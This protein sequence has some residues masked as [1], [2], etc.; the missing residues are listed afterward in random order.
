[1]RDTHQTAATKISLG[2]A[3][4]Y[5]R[6]QLRLVNTD[7]MAAA[8]AA[9]GEHDVLQL[10][11]EN[12]LIDE[13]TTRTGGRYSPDGADDLSE[14]K[15]DSRRTGK[16]TPDEANVK[17]GASLMAGAD[18]GLSCPL[19]LSPGAAAAAI[20]QRCKRVP[21]TVVSGNDNVGCETEGKFKK[22]TRRNGTEY[23]RTDASS[24]RTDVVVR[25]RALRLP[26]ALS[27]RLRAL[28]TRFKNFK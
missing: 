20:R 15:R 11:N 8:A 1:V 25:N 27:M 23:E 13:L 12:G 7:V 3:R 2:F 17:T 6:G 21:A 28:S 26:S 14:T 18:R 9:A 16:K 19:S 4:F 10:E 22:P 5:H 24:S